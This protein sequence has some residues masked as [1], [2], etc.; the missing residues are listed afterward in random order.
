MAVLSPTPPPPGNDPDSRAF[1]SDPWQRWFSGLGAA[2]QAYVQSYVK[3]ALAGSYTA[4][5]GVSGATGT[6]I[7]FPTG[8]FSVAPVVM[9]T[10]VFLPPGTISYSISV[11]SVTSTSAKVYVTDSAGALVAG[12]S[13]YYSAQLAG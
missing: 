13:F 3:G 12:V 9:A 7:T 8:R 4:G 2:V 5:S 6:T 1:S 10:V 11:D